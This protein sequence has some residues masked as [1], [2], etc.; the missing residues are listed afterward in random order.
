VDIRSIRRALDI[1]L[2]DEARATGIS[3]SRLSLAERGLAKLSDSERRAVENFLRARM[4]SE[5]Q[6]QGDNA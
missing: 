1:R 2:I 5:L 3:A 4:E 6:E